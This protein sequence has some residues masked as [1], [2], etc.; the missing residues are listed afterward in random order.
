MF[1]AFM[2][3]WLSPC[4]IHSGAPRPR[5]CFFF[6]RG[7]E[8]FS[9]LSDYGHPERLSQAHPSRLKGLRESLDNSAAD[10]FQALWLLKAKH[11]L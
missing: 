1:L 11:V 5:L 8:F 9:L 3:N 4:C 2:N 10:V 6:L 7:Q